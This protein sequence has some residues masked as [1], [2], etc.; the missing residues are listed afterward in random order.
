MR[1][2][3]IIIVVEWVFKLALLPQTVFNF[4]STPASVLLSSCCLCASIFIYSFNFKSLPPC[5]THKNKPRKHLQ[6][7]LP[8][9]VFFY[10]SAAI[11][12]RCLSDCQHVCVCEYYFMFSIHKQSQG[13]RNY[14]NFPYLQVY[15]SFLFMKLLQETDSFYTFI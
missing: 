14:H 15:A 7:K 4:N 8:L 5:D 1:F 9:A 12:R 6:E 10:A 11:Y 3:W 2:P 13:N